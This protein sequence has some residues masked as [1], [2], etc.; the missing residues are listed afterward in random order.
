V[1]LLD[2]STLTGE[3]VPVIR[4]AD[5][6]D[7][8]APLL[9]ARDLVFS[10]SECTAGEAQAVVTGT[11]MRTELG[12]IA[13]LS[14]RTGREESP[15]EHQVKRVAWLIAFVA[16]GAG[17]AF[18]PIGPAAGLSLAAAVS[19]AIGLLVANVPEGLLP[20]IT[21]AL[22][23]GVREMARRGALVKRL[24][25]VETLGSTS[26]ICTDKTGTLTQNKMHVTRVWTPAGEANVETPGP[27]PAAAQTVLLA[28][29]AFTCN[30]AGPAAGDSTE[31]ALAEL[32]AACGVDVSVDRRAATRR[33]LFRFD[34][35]LKLMSTADEQ[36]GRLVVNTKGAP[37]EVLARITRIRRG[38]DELAITAADRADAAHVMDD[39]ARQGLRVLALARGPASAGDARSRPA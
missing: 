5:T 2:M 15:L 9:E 7:G 19:F 6:V 18:L 21:L 24:S 16:V 35:R 10:G 25:A 37:E 33:A 26:V 32:A 1:I 13:A 36:D 3:S 30:T 12:R 8:Q 20:T 34:P 29:A 38:T 4:S 11:G 39:Y 14:Q 17:I 31:V 28:E 22:P 23:V 27:G